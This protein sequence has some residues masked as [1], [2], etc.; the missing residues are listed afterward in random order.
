MPW[1]IVGVIGERLR[2]VRAALKPVCAFTQLCRRFGISRRIGYKWVARFRRA[3]APALADRSRRPRRS[4][5]KTPLRWLQAL[6]QLRHRHRHWGARKIHDRW[7]RDHP[8]VGLPAVRTL[9]K[10]IRRLDPPPRRP[11]SVRGPAVTRPPLTQP[12]R[13]NEV[14]TADFKGWFRTTDG[15]RCHP[16]TVRDLH[17]RFLLAI[18]VRPRQQHADVRAVFTG[19]FR[20][21]GLPKIIRVDNGSPFGGTGALGLSV[22]SVWWLRLGIAVEFIRPG[23][24][25]DNGAHEQMHRELKRETAQPPARTLP[26]QQGRSQRWVRYYNHERPHEALGGGVPADRYRR[27]ARGYRGLRPVRYRRNWHRRQVR[28]NGQIKW[29]G[30]MRSIGEAFVGQLVGLRRCAS[31]CYEVYCGRARL[32]LLYDHDAGGLRPIRPHHAKPKP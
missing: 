17:S 23:H 31:D 19:L 16:L 25:E 14:W 12:T 4:P 30:R 10:W 29:Q 21:F 28:S 9:A 32:G 7:R 11:R 2:F 13:P 5:R 22:L 24:P 6:R 8:R 3:G 27:S 20:R 18:R 1:K 26:A 15:T